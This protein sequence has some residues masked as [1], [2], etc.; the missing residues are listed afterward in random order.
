MNT[1]TADV[2][3]TYNWHGRVTS[4]VMHD[5]LSG[6][7]QRTDYDYTFHPNG[8]LSSEVIKRT[9]PSGQVSSTA[10]YDT[11][12]NQVSFVNFAG[13]AKSWS[14]FNGRGQPGTHT[15]INGVSTS[16]VYEPN[17]DLKTITQNLASGNRVTTLKYNHDRQ[18][19]D[20]T[21]PNGQAARW[22]YTAGGRV[23]YTGDAQ[24]QFARTAVDLLYN[25]VTET[26][27]RKVPS[28]TGYSTPVP[29]T[30]TTEF[31]S[32]TAFDSLGRPY[33]K[34]GNHNQRMEYRH[35]KNGNLRTVTDAAN[36]TTS[37][38]YDG[39]N[40]LVKTTAPDGGVI[41]IH[42]DAAGNI[43][44]VRDPRPLQTT[45]TYNGSGQVLTRV[46]PDTGT[47]TYTYDSAD[48]L[49]TETSADGKVI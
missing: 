33:T 15:D 13:H 29:T 20:V 44:W 47:T 19:T 39:L 27:E 43:D 7:N 40:R 25:T 4:T 38:D 34:W 5:R 46:S 23:E 45:Y 11:S 42:Y 49:D 6:A 24:F 18:L 21:F 1:G 31:S 22:R 17:G 3:Y 8:T 35:D 36:R 48:M 2:T 32:K 41:D 12:G 26:A 14:N 9:L 30:A 28:L 16:F 10:T 37:N